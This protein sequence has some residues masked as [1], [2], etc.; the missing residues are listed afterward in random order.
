[1]VEDILDPQH[2]LLVAQL[3]KID[4]TVEVS[5]KV[6]Y[7][8]EQVLRAVVREQP[9]LAAAT[10]GSR[11]RAAGATLADRIEL[12]REIA[13]AI[14]ARA[15]RDRAWLLDRL[16]PL[17][18][19]FRELS[20]GSE[21]MVLDAAFLV[22]QGRLDRFDETLDAAAAEAGK[23]VRFNCVGPLPPYSFVD[24]RLQPPAH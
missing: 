7:E 6:T 14:A 11:G 9:H 23:G 13:A 20:R 16:G 2:D 10:G 24:L 8:E 5:L 4:G 21:L 18:V 22:R 12:G 1:V 17:A 3:E 19:D 15:D